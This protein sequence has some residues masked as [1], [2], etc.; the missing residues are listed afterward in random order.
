MKVSKR[1]KHFL[2]CEQG[3]T[4]TEYAIIG[5]LISILVIVVVA[6][7][8]QNMNDLYYDKVQDGLNN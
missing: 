7:I 3:T 8:G 1:F 6:G 2:N 5:G 4:V